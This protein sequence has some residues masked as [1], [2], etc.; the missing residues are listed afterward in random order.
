[1]RYKNARIDFGVILKRS[2]TSSSVISFSTIG[3]PYQWLPFHFAVAIVQAVSPF[4]MLGAPLRIRVCGPRLVRAAGIRPSPNALR[5]A[6]A[7]AGP[8]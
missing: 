4:A 8:S 2:A 3:V 5:F 1:M 6:A 7:I